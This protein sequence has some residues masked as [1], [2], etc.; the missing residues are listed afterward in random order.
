[1]SVHLSGWWRNLFVLLLVMV[2]LVVVLV[3]ILAPWQMINVVVCP[4]TNVAV[5][6]NTWFLNFL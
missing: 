2:A 4:V 1:M 6:P 5:A 3:P